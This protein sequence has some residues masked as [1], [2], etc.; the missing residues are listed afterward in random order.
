MKA[1]T[2]II[3]LLL[4]AILILAAAC[5]PA[6]SPSGQQPER[7]QQANSG[8]PAENSMPVAQEIGEGA[9]VFLFEVTDGEGNVN[10]W[11]VKTDAETVGA[12][13]V[14]VG[15]IEGTVSDFGLMVTHVNRVRADFVEDGAYWAFYVDGDFA[16]AGVDSTDIEEGVTYAFVYT[17][18]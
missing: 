3:A 4:A 1:K 12:A 17:P 13:L 9:K 15:L 2:K 18:A 11:N 8:A 5:G 10:A 16:M 14:E 7:R 6:G